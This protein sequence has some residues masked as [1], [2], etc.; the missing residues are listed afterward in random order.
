MN[1]A[2]DPEESNGDP[3]LLKVLEIRQGF[4]HPTFKLKDER[5][6]D[7]ETFSRS[8]L[9]VL[10]EDGRLILR[11]LV[12]ADLADTEHARMIKELGGYGAHLPLAW[13]DS[14]NHPEGPLR[15]AWKQ[16]RAHL[17]LLIF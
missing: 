8:E 13:G 14:A 16:L 5:L 1:E 15:S 4:I 17:R 2:I 3:A 12:K 11:V 7:P 6:F 10:Q 9:E